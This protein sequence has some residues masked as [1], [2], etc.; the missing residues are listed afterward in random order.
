MA[1]S[2]YL[3]R[4]SE[5]RVVVILSTI[6]FLLTIAAMPF[7]QE[8][9]SRM[10]TDRS[11][12][13][14]FRYSVE[15]LYEMAESYGAEGRREYIVMRFTFDLVFPLIYGAFLVSVLGW[16]YR[17]R[18]WVRWSGK[19]VLLPFM[20]LLFDYLENISTSIVM[21]RYPERIYLVGLLATI[22][23]PVKWV[24]LSLSFLALLPGLAL[25]LLERYSKLET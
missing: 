14:S 10:S 24:L 21:W 25:G 20:G 12:D 9:A 11:P 3:L 1:L 4:L 16:L 18:S 6:L 5:K 19:V 22:F 7:I 2:K 23:T 13:M 8:A 15:D 17:T